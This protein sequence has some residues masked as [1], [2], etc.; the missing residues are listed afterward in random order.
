MQTNAV[1]LQTASS[2]A[3]IFCLT[4]SDSNAAYGRHA[5]SKATPQAQA[6]AGGKKRDARFTVTPR[7]PKKA[8]ALAYANENVAR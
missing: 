5:S 8:R 7:L 6:Q 4:S 2:L 3:K 1:G